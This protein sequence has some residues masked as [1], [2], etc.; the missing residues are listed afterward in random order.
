[1]DSL[2]LWTSF[3]AGVL[4][5]L[6]PCVLPLLPVIV[7]GAA[8]STNKWQP[9]IMTTSLAISVVVF[10]LLLKASSVLI[11]VPQSFWTSLSGGIILLF[12]IVTTWP[13]IWE[14]I[15]LKFNL[16]GRSQTGLVTAGANDSA[17]SGVL[18]GAALGPVFS[19]CSPTYFV[20]LATVLPVSFAVGFVYLLVYAF[21]LALMLGLIAYFGQRLTIHLGW[22]ANPHG[23]FKKI[24]GILLILVGL[25]IVTGF[26]KDIEVKLLDAGFGTTKIEENLLDEMEEYMEEMEEKM[27][28]M[29]TTKDLQA[30]VDL[31]KLYKAPDFVG[32]ENWINSEPIDSLEDLKG[33]VVLIDFWTYSCINC[34]RTLPFLQSWHEK[35]ADDGLVVLGIHAPEFQFEKILKNVENAVDEFNFNFVGSVNTIKIR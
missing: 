22:A 34:I 28:E 25:A 32:L 24:L 9:L 21:G 19:S 30:K 11:N 13:I 31:P 7:G 33:K 17:W 23:W 3:V 16:L 27:E 5:V 20:I 4:T 15:S 2:L 1:M 6:A 29:E 14:K 8:G 10:T 18:V 26:E 12:G 35:Y